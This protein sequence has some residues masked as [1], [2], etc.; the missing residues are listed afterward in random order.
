MWCL[1][2][3][4]F[5]KRVSKF[6]SSGCSAERNLFKEALTAEADARTTTETW[7][8]HAR[9]SL[10]LLQSVM[11]KENH[12]F[13]CCGCLW[14]TASAHAF[15]QVQRRPMYLSCHWR[16][17]V[18]LMKFSLCKLKSDQVFRTPRFLGRGNASLCSCTHPYRAFLRATVESI[19]AA[20]SLLCTRRSSSRT[21]MSLKHSPGEVLPQAH[22]TCILLP[23]PSLS[24]LIE[25]PV[26][27]YLSE[28]EHLCCRSILCRNVSWKFVNKR[29][30]SPALTPININRIAVLFS[31]KYVGVCGNQVCDALN[32]QRW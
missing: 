7:E 3:M 28:L 27:P 17:Y 26:T 18:V 6:P 11:S 1:S 22:G 25:W 8:L 4:V 14:M 16:H 30:S 20:L 2:R 32:S 29:C 13:C 9:H 21:R 12:C 5:R 23:P 15:V 24:C 19:R 10:H 31:C